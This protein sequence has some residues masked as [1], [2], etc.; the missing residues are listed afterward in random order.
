MGN[1]FVYVELHS[2]DTKKA[3]DFYGAMFD[4]EF[5]A[6]ETPM[7]PYTFIK[8]GDGTPGGLAAHDGSKGPSHWLSYINVDDIDAATDK[9]CSLGAEL[10]QGKTQVPSMGWFTVLADPTGAKIAL[11]QSAAES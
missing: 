8:P 7:G 6:M 4:W 1:P 2:T 3:R 5:E 10:L 9:A 11:W